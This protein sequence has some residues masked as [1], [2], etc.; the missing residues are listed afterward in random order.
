M[1]Q[2]SLETVFLI[3]ICCQSGDKWQSKTLFLAIVDL[4]LLDSINVFDCRLS[5]VETV[6]I[7]I[8]PLL[9]RAVLIMASRVDFSS[10]VAWPP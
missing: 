3:A 2:K 1:D 8:C 10:P 7:F 4:R 9:Q 6:K 5:G